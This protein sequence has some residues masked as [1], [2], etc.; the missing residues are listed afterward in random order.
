MET[1]TFKSANKKYFKHRVFELLPD[2]LDE[3]VVVV[4]ECKPEEVDGGFVIFSSDNA[5]VVDF[6]QWPAM[7][8]A[9]GNSMDILNRASLVRGATYEIREFLS[10]WFKYDRTEKVWTK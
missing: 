10:G 2:A 8:N 1:P 6:T 9:K 5:I 3:T 4:N 7:M